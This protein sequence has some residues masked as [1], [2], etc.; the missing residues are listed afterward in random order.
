MRFPDA[1]QWES[2]FETVGKLIES[3]KLE[4]VLQA[5]HHVLTYLERRPHHVHVVLVVD[6]G[7][8]LAAYGDLDDADA[9]VADLASEG[10]AADVVSV[11]V[12]TA[13]VAR[14]VLGDDPTG[15]PR[16]GRIAGGAVTT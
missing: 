9:H 8:V 2:I 6:T 4:M 13:Y 15:V 5:G 7:K 12:R 3:P 11:R 1:S 14:P 16:A 10:R